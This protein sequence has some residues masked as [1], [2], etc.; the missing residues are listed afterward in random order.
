MAHTFL[1]LAPRDKSVLLYDGSSALYR[2]RS[3]N[4]NYAFRIFGIPRLKAAPHTRIFIGFRVSPTSSTCLNV[5]SPSVAS[6]FSPGIHEAK[7]FQTSFEIYKYICSCL[8][9]QPPPAKTQTYNIDYVGDKKSSPRWPQEVSRK[10]LIG[11]GPACGS[12]Y[13]IIG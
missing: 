12:D 5:G 8:S 11:I 1:L 6:I 7:S 4:N 3:T 2:C 10:I 13:T 9:N